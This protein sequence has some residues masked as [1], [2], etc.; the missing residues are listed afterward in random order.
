[1]MITSAE[2]QHGRWRN[3]PIDHIDSVNKILLN[4]EPYIAMTDRD[5]QCPIHCSSDI[6]LLSLLIGEYH[7]HDKPEVRQRAGR[8]FIN[9]LTLIQVW[10]TASIVHAYCRMITITKKSGCSFTSN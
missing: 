6:L 7:Q 3:R 1:M 8:I 5:Q 2:N 10:R 4:E 9:L